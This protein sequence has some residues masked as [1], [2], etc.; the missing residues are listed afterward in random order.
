MGGKEKSAGC[1][2]QRCL[3]EIV[4]TN[5]GHIPLKGAM[6]SDSPDRPNPSDTDMT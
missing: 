6:V 5:N 3:V 1:A 2:I 4:F